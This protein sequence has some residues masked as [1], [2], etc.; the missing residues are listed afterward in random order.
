MPFFGKG[1]S[2]FYTLGE[3]NWNP[4]K[5][6]PMENFK[7]NKINPIFFQTPEIWPAKHQIH[8]SVGIC[9]GKWLNSSFET[10]KVYELNP[11]GNG[12]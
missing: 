3:K 2:L 11:F 5:D 10:W 12:N 8:P 7:D 4:A 9:Q 6:S 1:K